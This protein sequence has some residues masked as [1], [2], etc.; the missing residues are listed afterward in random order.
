MAV[1]LAVGTSLVV[2]GF[3]V[4]EMVVVGIVV[5]AAAAAEAAAVGTVVGV[6]ETPVLSRNK[7]GGY[8]KKRGGRLGKYGWWAVKRGRGCNK[9]G[10]GGS[11]GGSLRSI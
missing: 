7:M 9:K 6:P 3:S 8:S 1:Q 5:G 2:V 11:G 4:V 10:A